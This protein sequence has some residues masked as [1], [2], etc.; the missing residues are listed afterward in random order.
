MLIMLDCRASSH[1]ILSFNLVT[2]CHGRHH[3]DVPAIAVEQVLFALIASESHSIRDRND[4][5]SFGNPSETKNDFQD[6]S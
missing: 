4:L 3:H 2:D 6:I 1:F 5:R